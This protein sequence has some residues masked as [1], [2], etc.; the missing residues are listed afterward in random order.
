[1]A[2]TGL[3]IEVGSRMGSW[4]QAVLG[5]TVAMDAARGAL[6]ELGGAHRGQAKARVG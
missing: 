1:M 6:L 4:G 2:D 3:G 5:A